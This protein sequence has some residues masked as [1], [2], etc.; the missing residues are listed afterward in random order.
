M[1]SS[2]TQSPSSRIAELE[3]QLEATQNELA[4]LRQV[5]QHVP[6]SAAL[7]DRDMR[8]MQVTDEYYQWFRVDAPDIIG[9]RAHEVMPVP[10]EWVAIHNRAFSGEVIAGNSQTQQDGRDWQSQWVVRPWYLLDGSVGGI[11]T[12]S[13]NTTEAATNATQQQRMRILVEQSPNQIFFLDEAATI[14]YFN[15]DNPQASLMG[16]HFEETLA[17]DFIAI[18]REALRTAHDTGEVVTYE[19]KNT[20]DEWHINRI[21][22]L[23]LSD[24]TLQ[25]YVVSSNNISSQKQ[26]RAEQARLQEELI[27]AQQNAIRELATPIIPLDDRLILV[28]LIGKVTAERARD[29]MRLILAGIQQHRAR[30]LLLDITGV[31]EITFESSEGI[32]RLIIAGRLKGTRTIVVGISDAV[33]EMMSDLPID[34]QAFDIAPTLQAGIALAKRRLR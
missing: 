34:W 2:N 31:P 21:S 3:A 11:I 26:A 24:K 5:I 1:Y 15:R 27:A 18:F 19:V 8:Y 23:Y 10:P 25:G 33:A 28:P 9:K 12:C 7:Y 16:Q 22:A 30:T 13:Q 6:V 14:D 20:R 32:Y 17:A 4:A 29:M